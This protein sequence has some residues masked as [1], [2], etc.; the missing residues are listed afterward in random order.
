MNNALRLL[1]AALL[2]LVV[3][4]MAC[5]SQAIAQDLAPSSA[6]EARIR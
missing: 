4:A 3:I 1:A 5:R 6:C 2:L